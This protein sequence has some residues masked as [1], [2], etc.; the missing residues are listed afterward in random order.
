MSAV[1]AEQRKPVSQ[2]LLSALLTLCSIGGALCLVALIAAL[3]LDITLIMFKTG[4]MAPTIPAGSVAVVQEVRADSLSVGDVVTVDRPGSLPVTHRVLT[5]TPAGDGLVTIT[6]QG[7][8]NS[9]P[10]P[11][12]YT[13]ERVRTVLWSAPGLAPVLVAASKPA[14]MGGITVGV[15]A[16]VM[17]V[18]W[19]RGAKSTSPRR[20]RAHRASSDRDRVVS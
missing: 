16:L 2:R 19:P 10:D 1:E 17:L 15:S 20:R 13:V 18:L 12:P 3:L 14:V 7:D 9:V 8:A 4:S 11:A 6:M 5:V